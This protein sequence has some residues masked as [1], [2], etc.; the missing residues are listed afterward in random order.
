M[1]IAVIGATGMIG[2]EITTEAARRGHQVTAVSRSGSAVEAAPTAAPLTAQLGD[3]STIGTLAE[4]NDVL[5]FATTPSRTGGDHQ[6]WLAE[7]RAAF[8]AL[9]STPFLVIGGAGSLT[10]NGQRLIDDPGFPEI[11]RPEALT[12]TTLLEE[13][14]EAPT[15]VNWTLISP[16]PVIAPGERTGEYKLGLDSPAGE[17]ISSQDFAVAI[18][19]ELENPQHNRKRFTAAN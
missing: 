11:Y 4:A 10:A 14:R 3:T 2:R 7:S 15:G 13:L 6:E 1:K 5:V 12:L 8:K 16:S 9:G 19:D 17:K 18:V